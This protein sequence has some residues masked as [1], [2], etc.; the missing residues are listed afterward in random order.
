MKGKSSMVKNAL[1]FTFAI[2][3]P[4]IAVSEAYHKGRPCCGS[5]ANYFKIETL[6]SFSPRAVLS[7]ASKNPFTGQG[8]LLE[9]ALRA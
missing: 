4:P 7:G 6:P 1:S 8:R 2:Y 5:C 3:D 9:T